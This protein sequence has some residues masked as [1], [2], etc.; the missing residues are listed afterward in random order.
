MYTCM[1]YFLFLIRLNW[2]T[3]LETVTYHYTISA[4]YTQDLTHLHV[5]LHVVSIVSDILLLLQR[6]VH[7]YGMG[8]YKHE[9]T[10]DLYTL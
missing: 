3:S 2:T 8:D 4:H 9:L 7:N 6:K 1:S 5:L 10:I